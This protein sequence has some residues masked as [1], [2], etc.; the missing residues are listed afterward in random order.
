MAEISPEKE[1]VLTQKPRVLLLGSREQNLV[2]Y[3]GKNLA[4]WDVAPG[5]PEV[6]FNAL[7]GKIWY[8]NYPGSDYAWET[9]GHESFEPKYSLVPLLFGTIKATIYSMLFATPISI[10]AAI[11]VSQFM[12]P[13]WKSRIKPII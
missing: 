8:E 1:S 4:S 11:Y 3:D 5:Y 12:T 7:F 13:S 2:A 6:S 9:T 10:F